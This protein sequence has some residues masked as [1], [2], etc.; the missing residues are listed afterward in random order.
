MCLFWSPMVRNSNREPLCGA[1]I[2]SDMSRESGVFAVPVKPGSTE[3]WNPRRCGILVVF[4]RAPR[5]CIPDSLWRLCMLI[6]SDGSVRLISV[7][8]WVMRANFSRSL[9][10][11]H[12]SGMNTFCARSW[13]S[14]LLADPVPWPP[15]PSLRCVTVVFAQCFGDMRHK[16]RAHA[17]IREYDEGAFGVHFSYCKK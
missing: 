9:W 1:G 12:L 10:T 5:F 17:R 6:A 2:K 15:P 8:E 7:A 14:R 11:A 16:D 3:N 4:L 13:A